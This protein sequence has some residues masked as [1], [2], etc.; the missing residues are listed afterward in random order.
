MKTK[1]TNKYL[2]I[3]YKYNSRSKFRL[4]CSNYMQA[5][6]INFWRG[7]VYWVDCNGKRKLLKRVYN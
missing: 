1:E 5:I 4:V 3:G 6:G 2:V 7:S